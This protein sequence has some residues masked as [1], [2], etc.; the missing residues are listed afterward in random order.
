MYPEE[1]DI[2]DQGDEK[3]LKTVFANKGERG[4]QAAPDFEKDQ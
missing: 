3:T 1:Y 2:Y 4:L